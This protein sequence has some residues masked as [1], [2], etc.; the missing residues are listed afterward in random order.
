VSHRINGIL[1]LSALLALSVHSALLFG[2]EWSSAPTVDMPAARDQGI[3]I[4]LTQASKLKIDRT[5]PEKIILPEPVLR[6]KPEKILQPKVTQPKIMPGPA[7]SRPSAQSKQTPELSQEAKSIVEAANSDSA[8]S[9]P[10]PWDALSNPRPIY[11]ELARRRGQEGLVR[12]RAYIDAKGNILE[13]IIEQSSGYSLLD[14]AA[15]QAVRK[16]RFRPGT[17]AGEAV[18]GSVLIPVDFQLRR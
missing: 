7:Q 14:E 6:P 4:D 13:L 10:V 1:P 5:P 17:R 9:S 2:W 12:L 3:N 8:S 16:W 11:P 15:V 18:A